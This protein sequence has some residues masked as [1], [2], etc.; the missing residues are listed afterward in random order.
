MANKS[1]VEVLFFGSRART[2]FGQRVAGPRITNF[3]EE[4]LN[5]RVVP[6]IEGAYDKMT[7][8]WS[9]KPTPTI[10]VGQRKNVGNF[11][12][13]S[14]IPDS[15]ANKKWLMVDVE[16]RRGGAKIFRKPKFFKVERLALPGTQEFKVG[17]KGFKTRYGRLGEIH[18]P[19]FEGGG[20]G[21]GSRPRLPVSTYNPRTTHGG[22]FGGPGSRSGDTK[23]PLVVIQGSVTSRKL[24]ANNIATAL[25]G[26]SSPLSG[27]VKPW[28]SDS[29]PTR[30]AYRAAFFRA[31]GRRI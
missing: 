8:G 23:Y 1:G 26:Q 3:M 19:I 27:I 29:G 20:R 16:G 11:V 9:E 13:V 24:T 31:T 14:F 18:T 30:A 15:N 22:G 5:K 10:K 17:G 4:E 12:E 28:F 6:Q 7:E 21:F 2:G 25:R